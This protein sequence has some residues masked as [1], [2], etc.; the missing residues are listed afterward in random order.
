[1]EAGRVAADGLVD[2]IKKKYGKA[3]GDVAL[4]TPTSDIGLL[5]QRDKGFLEQLSTKYPD[6]KLVTYKG[7][8]DGY[9]TPAW[10]IMTGLITTNPNCHLYQAIHREQNQRRELRTRD[11]PA[12]PSHPAVRPIKL[13]SS[14]SL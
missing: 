1:M 4:I 5:A 2:A 3:K 8:T 12:V 13:R 6:L 14:T 10:D 11:S 9:A 7:V